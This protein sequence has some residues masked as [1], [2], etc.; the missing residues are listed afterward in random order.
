MPRYEIRPMAY[1][2]A[3]PV[4]LATQRARLKAAGA[5]NIREAYLNGW[6]NQPRTLRFGARDDDAAKAI[7]NAVNDGGATWGQY[8]EYGM[9]W[10]GY[11]K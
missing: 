5:R 3:C 11:G 6:R 10:K 4:P 8:R 7:A 9:H 1:A 2:S